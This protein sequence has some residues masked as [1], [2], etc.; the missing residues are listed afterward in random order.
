MLLNS[1]AE[2]SQIVIQYE[3]MY[4]RFVRARIFDLRFNGI[5]DEWEAVGS[6]F[7]GNACILKTKSHSDGQTTFENIL[8][9][10]EDA[11][12][13]KDLLIQKLTHPENVLLDK[14]CDEI[15]GD[16]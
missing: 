7:W 8:Y 4:R 11:A 13:E 6:A 15:F 10:Q 9:I 16:G 2:I 12:A 14:L 3:G 5:G 1:S